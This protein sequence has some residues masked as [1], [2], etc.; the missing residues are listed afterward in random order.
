MGGSAIAPEPL[1]FKPGITAKPCHTGTGGHHHAP[2]VCATMPSLT[3]DTLPASSQTI[4]SYAVPG[5]AV[6]AGAREVFFR[7][8]ICL[9]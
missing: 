5:G 6:G 2:D 7:N 9:V 8:G 3:P 4:I 1:S